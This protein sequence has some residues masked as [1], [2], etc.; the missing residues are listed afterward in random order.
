MYDKF[1]LSNSDG[2]FIIFDARNKE[3]IDPEWKNILMRT[4]KKI[5]K[6]RAVIVGLR[7]SD[8]KNYPQLMDEFVIDNDLEEKIVSVLFLKIGT[9]YREKMYDHL[10]LMLELIVN[11]RKLK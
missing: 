5:R 9:D 8:D 6:K 7:V 10:I 4:I 2:V 1:N 3:H 11:T